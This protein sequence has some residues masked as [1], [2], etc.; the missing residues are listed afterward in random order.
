[1]PA[2]DDFMIRSQQHAFNVGLR[3][4]LTHA[5]EVVSTER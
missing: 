2:S 4:S 5:E 3:Y 1:M